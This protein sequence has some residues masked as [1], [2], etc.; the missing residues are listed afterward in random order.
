[1]ASYRRRSPARSVLSKSCSPLAVS[2]LN[3]LSCSYDCPPGDERDASGICLLHQ[4]G[5]QFVSCAEAF[6]T[7]ATA[8]VGFPSVVLLTDGCESIKK[9]SP[10]SGF[11]C[12]VPGPGTIGT[13]NLPQNPL[14]PESCGTTCLAPETCA[15]PFFRGR[16]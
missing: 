8:R 10:C 5:P 15:A 6:Q 13:R 1:M 9:S 12:K 14:A 16:N 4:C 11:A 2:L 7:R 3:F